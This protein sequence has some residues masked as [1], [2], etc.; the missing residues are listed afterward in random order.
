MN[1]YAVVTGHDKLNC[2]SVRCMFTSK[3]DAQK[4]LRTLIEEREEYARFW[5]HPEFGSRDIAATAKK[6]LRAIR[7]WEVERLS[8]YRAYRNFASV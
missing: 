4:W 2:P 5:S 1:V 7:K 6:E 3:R 8:V